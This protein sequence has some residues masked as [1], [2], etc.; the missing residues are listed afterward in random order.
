MIAIPVRLALND[1]S[2]NS[3][4][5]K[6]SSKLLQL[7]RVL[8]F[9]TDFHIMMK[10]TPLVLILAMSILSSGCN[11]SRPLSEVPDHAIAVPTTML[12]QGGYCAHDSAA[13]LWIDDV[14][15]FQQ[16]WQEMHRHQLPAPEAPSV[17]FNQQVV[18]AAFL[19][20]RGSGGHSISVTSVSQLDGK[21]F[22]SLKKQAPGAN[23]FTTSAI[24]QPYVLVSVPKEGIRSHQFIVS[25]EVVDCEP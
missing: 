6:R 21:A 20:T 8:S 23:C 4:P 9:A 24:T 22:V 17:D 7:L 19:G 12:A 2:F 10:L 13:N 16:L 14:A 1:S 25:D 18:I 11:S 15:A 5:S 3:F